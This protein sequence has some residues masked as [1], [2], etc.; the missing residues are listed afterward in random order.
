M[1]ILNCDCQ[2]FGKHHQHSCGCNKGDS[3]SRF[4][5]HNQHQHH[6]FRHQCSCSRCGH[7]DGNR[8]F[9]D[10]CLCDDRFRI[11]LSG[12]RSS[13]AFRFRQLIGEHVKVALEGEKIVQGRITFVGNDFIEI[14]VKVKKEKHKH[15]VKKKVF[16]VQFDQIKWVERIDKF[17]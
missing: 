8:H 10:R 1:S 12:L 9:M 11:R 7:G 5:S 4:H 14:V 13:M 16:L 17:R 2:D 6:D 15:E 3:F